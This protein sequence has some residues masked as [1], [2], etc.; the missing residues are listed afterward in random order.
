VVHPVTPR[1]HPPGQPGEPVIPQPAPPSSSSDGCDVNCNDPCDS[2]C[3]QA[4]DGT[5]GTV[6]DSC[7]STGASCGDAGS[8]CGDTGSSC[9]GG[10]VDCSSTVASGQLLVDTVAL[11]MPWL[12]VRARVT[13]PAWVGIGAI[14]VYQRFVSARLG[15]RCRYTPSCSEYGVHA[16]RRFGALDGALV[17]LARIRRCA[18]DVPHG[19]VDALG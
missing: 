16:L 4:V 13:L 7:D 15:T 8:S 17:A 11:R 2:A 3:D 19:T 14:R 18:P 6:T 5:C 12:S 1:T 9:D 10:S